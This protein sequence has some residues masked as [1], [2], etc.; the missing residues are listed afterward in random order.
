MICKIDLLKLYKGTKTDIAKN[1]IVLVIHLHEKLNF[2]EHVKE[3]FAKRW[4]D[5]SLV[6]KL[7]NKLPRNTLI[8]QINNESFS[9]K[10]EKPQNKCNYWSYYLHFMRKALQGIK[11]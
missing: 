9:R 10:L 6:K 7:Q 1:N 4:K 2:N 5:V 11:P 3:K 8:N